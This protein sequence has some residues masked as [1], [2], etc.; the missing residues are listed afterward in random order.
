MFGVLDHSLRPPG[1]VTGR[2]AIES[3]HYPPLCSQRVD[4]LSLPIDTLDLKGKA[5]SSNTVSIIRRT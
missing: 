5:M 4:D 2:A 1:D 3:C